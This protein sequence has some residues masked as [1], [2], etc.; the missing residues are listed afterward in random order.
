MSSNGD[1]FPITLGM[2]EELFLVD[3][4]S[5]DLL[6]DPPNEIFEFC[7]ETCGPHK[8]VREFLRS[9]IETNTKVC[10]SIAE[11]RSSVH[12][13]RKV[14]IRAAE[15]SGFTTMA[16]STHPFASWRE[17]LP[18][19]GERYERFAQTFQ[20]GVRQFMISGMHIHAGFGDVDMRLRV[21][22]AIRR[23]L[24]LLHALSTSSPF[25]SGS[26]TGF[27]SYRLS[28]VGNLPRTGMPGVFQSRQEFDQLVAQYQASNFIETSS[29]LWWDIRPSYT[30]PTI[31]MRICDVC[32]RVEDAICIA[33]LYACL[34]R[35]LARLD[36]SG[37]LP[38][39]PLTEIIAEDRW[40]AQR[41]GV[42]AFFGD[43]DS[44]AGRVDIHDYVSELL[45]T[46][47]DDARALDCEAEIRRAL[48]IV[49]EGTS[50]DRQIDLY[51]LCLLDGAT[52]S[53]ALRRVV[54]LAVKETAESLLYE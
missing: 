50:A 32:T 4:D 33:A 18:T 14:V 26:E 38:R 2:E 13:A 19:P 53:E 9:Q 27:K 5:L 47:V 51:R 28:L 15:R 52:E 48:D 29:E 3:P 49:K 41:Y 40:I 16:A 43:M 17:Q 30:Y 44:G 1:Q 11:L 10:N 25:S 54:E 37:A 31:E 6:V 7:Q 8:V 20:E 34:I 45:D 23:F 12:E 39:E 24:P 22:T 36:R 21:M 42:F 46:L 35:W